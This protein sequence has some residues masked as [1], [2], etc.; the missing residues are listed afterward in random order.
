MTDYTLEGPKWGG[1]ALGSAGGTITW[2]VDGTI[3]AAFLPDIAT[4][5]ANW[6]SYANIAFQQVAATAGAN[7]TFTETPIDGVSHVL[8]STS[9]RYSGT[10]LSSATVTFDSGEGWH[11]TGTG[12]VSQDGAKLALVATREV[13]HAIGLGHYDAAPA[14]MNAT[15]DPAVTGLTRS[16]I[17][18][19][20]ALYGLAAAGGVLAYQ[21]ATVAGAAPA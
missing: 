11:G 10:T 17:D 4:A 15:L 16:D 13:G 7:I 6:A 20:E 14:V 19:V 9:Y 12:T 8:G 3:P 18:G 21:D 5:F 2:A 1:K